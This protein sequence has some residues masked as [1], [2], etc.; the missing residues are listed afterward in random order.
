[1]IAGKEARL[2]LADPI[3]AL[4]TRQI[5][6]TGETALNPKLVKLLVIKGAER[7]RQAA[8][9]S[10]E[11][12]LRGNDVNDETEPHL[13]R[14]RETMFGLTLHL[15]ERIARREK[16]RVHCI[17]GIRRISKIADL[18]GGAERATHQITAGP[19][20]PGPYTDE[21]SQEHIGPGLEA[22]KP[23]PFNQVI[24]EL[25]EAISGF[26][27]GEARASDH[28]KSNIGDA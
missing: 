24:A 9:R 15:D 22:L 7:R 16:E 21:G 18:V 28:A 17:G 6:I 26:V 25:T 13:L 5:R 14:K 20:V 10:D 1:M 19:D 23:A 27:V 2:Q 3:P 12:E 11:P 8:Q 4:G